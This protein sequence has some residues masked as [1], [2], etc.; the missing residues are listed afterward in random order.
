[1]PKVCNS[2]FYSPLVEGPTVAC[3]IGLMFGK[4]G[5][6]VVVS[7][8]VLFCAHIDIVVFRG[9]KDVVDGLS[10]DDAYR[11]GRDAGDEV[12]IEGRTPMSFLLLMAKATTK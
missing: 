5:G 2:L 4:G 9:V 1:M 12:G 8:E 10:L 11:S 3:G 7:A 6:E